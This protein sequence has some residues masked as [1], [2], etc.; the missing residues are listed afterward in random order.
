MRPPPVFGG[1]SAR[2]MMLAG[3]DGKLSIATITLQAGDCVIMRT[4]VIK[5]RPGVLSGAP[6]G[7]VLAIMEMNDANG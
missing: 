6:T 7:R 4:A 1:S 2:D 3:C 5:V